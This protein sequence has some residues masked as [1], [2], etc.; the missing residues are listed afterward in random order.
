MFAAVAAA[1]VTAGPCAG[2]HSALVDRV[3]RWFDRPVCVTVEPSVVHHTCAALALTHWRRVHERR[4]LLP[5]A[6]RVGVTCAHSR[7]NGSRPNRPFVA[8]S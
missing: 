1:A 6:A 3:T 2:G 5:R 8:V 7:V 4:E